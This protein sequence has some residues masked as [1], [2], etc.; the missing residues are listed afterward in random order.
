MKTYPVSI[1]SRDPKTGELEI[2]MGHRFEDINEIAWHPTVEKLYSKTNAWTVTHIPT[3]LAIAFFNKI[4]KARRF[5]IAIRK[6]D[7]DFTKKDLDNY[8]PDEKRGLFDWIN[9]IKGIIGERKKKINS[10][11]GK[12]F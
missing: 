5:T 12:M 6:Y 8:T 1:S 11:T 2:I 9:K 3:G 10:H 4:H 7:W